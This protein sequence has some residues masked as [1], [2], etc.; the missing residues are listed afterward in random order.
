[1]G[2]FRKPR[3]DPEELE[4]IKEQV[5]FMRQHLDKAKGN[6]QD[7]SA[8]LDS[9]ESTNSAMHEQVGA[10]NE[11]AGRLSDLGDRLE[12]ADT[13]GSVQ[14]AI[15]GLTKRL[16]DVSAQLTDWSD[17]HEELRAQMTTLDGRITSVSTELVNQITE[18]G[19]DI[20]ALNSRTPEG[21]A[22]D[23]AQVDELRSGQ[24]RL[25]NEQ[26]RYQ[27][28]FREDLARLAEQLRRSS[29]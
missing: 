12:S 28:A 16:D 5:R 11:L 21:V 18:L 2:L 19:N 20:E 1:M 9:I 6:R 4:R 15:D 23:P 29:H 13:N 25:A 10:F 7:V 22:P 24:E 14:P 17:Q 3:V 26:A 27:I 8:R